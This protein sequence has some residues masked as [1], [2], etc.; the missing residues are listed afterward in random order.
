MPRPLLPDLRM[1]TG[2]IRKPGWL[3][4]DELDEALRG[5]RGRARTCSKAELSCPHCGNEWTVYEVEGLEA[6]G[7]L[8]PRCGKEGD[9]SSMV[10]HTFAPVGCVISHHEEPV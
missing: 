4:S 6:S 8:C 1:L 3:T 9:L 2:K 10:M 5:E 7:H